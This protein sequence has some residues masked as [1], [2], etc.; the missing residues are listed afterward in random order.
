MDNKVAFD[1][2]HEKQ[3]LKLWEGD[4]AVGLKEGLRLT[5]ILM[6]MCTKQVFPAKRQVNPSKC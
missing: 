3:P 4:Y 2:Q 1:V 6:S 5:A